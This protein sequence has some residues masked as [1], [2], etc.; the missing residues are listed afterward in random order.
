MKITRYFTLA[1][2]LAFAVAAV[3]SFAS[4]A[5]AQESS[6][7]FTLPYAA[8][9]GVATLPAG[10][11]QYSIDLNSS[12]PIT[13]LRKFAPNP[14]GFML[15]A[16]SISEASFSEPNRLVVE[17]IGSERVVTSM[18]LHELGLVLRYPVSTAK[19]DEVATRSL[20]HAAPEG[21]P[22]VNQ[23]GQ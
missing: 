10:E 19:T 16:T 8:R 13:T 22:A 18:Y 12:T 14:T 3:S 7:K 1:R 17:R 15:M 4:F 2:S 6:G 9:F 5:H 11:Y 23:Q 21:K 20:A